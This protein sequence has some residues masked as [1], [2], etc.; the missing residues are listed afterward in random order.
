MTFDPAALRAEFPILALRPHGQPLHYL[1]NGATA[2]VPRAVL[3]AIMRHETGA[4]ANVK[5]SVHYLAEAATEAYEA[6]RNT[7]A[8]YLN[9]ADADEIVFTSGCTAAINLLAHSFGSRLDP[10]DE[11]L[12]SVLEHHSNIVPWQML[13]ERRGIV[14]KAIPVTPEGRLDLDRMES[15]LG[16]RTRLVAL[17]HVSNVTGAET[18]V[19][20]VVAAAGAVG[21]RVFLDGAQRAPHGP[22][23]VRGLGIDFYACSGHKM[24]GPN[25]IGVLWGRKELLETMPPFLGGGEMI[26]RVTIERTSYAE[27]PRRFEAGTP[28]I[29][30]AVGLAAAAKWIAGL[31]QEAVHAHLARLTGRLLEGLARFRKLRVI[32]PQGLQARYP[33]VSFAIDGAHPHDV[34]QILDRH[35][36]A[37]RGGHHC[38]QPL[39]D[40]FG[41]AGTTRASLA[42]Y[43]DSDDIDALLAGLDDAMTRLGR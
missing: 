20:R 14:L 23:D 2:Q 31:D 27:V 29:A 15:L 38:A 28:P 19:A 1:D 8:T 11:V 26:E 21:A 4:R 25:G 13:R 36:V 10:G 43:N 39:M 40:A 6:A 41:V 16:K 9:A 17:T 37:L 42:C 24:F 3:D 30:Q 18:D 12:V 33:V 5:R 7:L 35:G 32:G 22:L 34:C